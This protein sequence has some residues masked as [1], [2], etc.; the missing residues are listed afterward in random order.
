M[1]GRQRDFDPLLLLLDDQEGSGCFFVLAVG[2]AGHSSVV[3]LADPLTLTF[4]PVDRAATA[5][6]WRSPRI[7]TMPSTR[8]GMKSF[9]DDVESILI[10]RLDTFG[11]YERCVKVSSFLGQGYANTCFHQSTRK[12]K[13]AKPNTVDKEA[14]FKYNKMRR[15]PLWY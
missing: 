2:S 4:S 6:P 1:G 11:N 5:E 3:G 10:S 9:I 13:Q 8:D 12:N 14:R 15:P 7:E